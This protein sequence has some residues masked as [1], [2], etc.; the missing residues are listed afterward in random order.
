MLVLSR[1]L[2]QSLRV[3]D[4]VRITVVKIDNNAV[5]IGIEAPEDVPIRRQEVAFELP[6]PLSKEAAEYR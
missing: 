5:R 3:G 2:G 4:G 1:K 6:E